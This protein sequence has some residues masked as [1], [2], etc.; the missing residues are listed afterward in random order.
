[1]ESKKINFIKK[2]LNSDI[3]KRDK[4]I[5]WNEFLKNKGGN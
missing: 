3:S 5:K 4:I 2:L 1:M